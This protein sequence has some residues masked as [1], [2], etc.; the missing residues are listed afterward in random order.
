MTRPASLAVL[1]F[2]LAAGAEPRFDVSLTALGPKKIMV[3]KEVRTATG[4]G[5]ADAKALVERPMPVLVKAGLTRAEADA[6][7][8][9]LADAGAGAALTPAG[10]AARAPPPAPA[11]PAGFAVKLESFGEAKIGCIKVVRDA[12]GLGLAD[13]KKLVE[14]APV[15]VKSGL[16]QQAAQKLAAALTAAGGTAKV[17]P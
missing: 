11:G 10:E 3:I 17:E 9:A 1:L 8:K 4:L 6:L 14:S 13:T 12:T 7:V 2:A 16:T 15:V 5:L